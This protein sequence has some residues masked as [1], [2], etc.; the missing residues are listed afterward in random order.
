MA[1]KLAEFISPIVNVCV[2]VCMEAAFLVPPGPAVNLACVYNN[3]EF[4][5]HV[6]AGARSED[7]TFHRAVKSK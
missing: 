2:F 3:S 7:W 1:D 6:S 4:V 5:V